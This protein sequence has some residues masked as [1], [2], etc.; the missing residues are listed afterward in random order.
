[1]ADTQLQTIYC[2]GCLLYWTQ[3][4]PKTI[5]FKTIQT[6]QTIQTENMMTQESQKIA[7]IQL[8]CNI[9]EKKLYLNFVSKTVKFFWF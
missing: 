9:N 7:Q 2:Y 4:Y 3:Y 6:I 8:K 5:I 1:M